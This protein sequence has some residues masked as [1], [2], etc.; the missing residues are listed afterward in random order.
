MV[1]RLALFSMMLVF[2]G[3]EADRHAQ[4]L[5]FNVIQT[6]IRYE[7]EVDKKI[8]AEKT[9]YRDQK[10]YIHAS[11]VGRANISKIGDETGEDIKG[12][13]L[14]GRIHTQAE[15]DARLTAEEIVSS[16]PPRIFGQVID[17]ITKGVKDDQ[18]FFLDILE[19][20]RRLDQNLLATLEKIDQQKGKLKNSRNM[21]TSLAS[22]VDIA[23]QVQQILE[24]GKAVQQEID[25]G[26]NTK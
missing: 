15:R 1:K 24:F 18:A 13:L 25:K 23:E 21:L 22:Q 14:Y 11:L 6:S 16:N 10:A 8:A 4:Q 3:C 17:Y 5:A 26:K 2:G 19:R 9:F 20:Q 7:A 12:T